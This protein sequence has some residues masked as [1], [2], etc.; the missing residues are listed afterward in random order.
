MEESE[1]KV[2]KLDTPAV[3]EKYATERR[4]STNVGGRKMSRIGPPPGHLSAHTDEGV[5]EY[6]KLVALEADNSIKYRTCS[7]QK[8]I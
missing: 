6:A 3:D 4:G 2:P 1:Y 8:V 5:D 7:W